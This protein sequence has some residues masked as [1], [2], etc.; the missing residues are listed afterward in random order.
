MLMSVA[1]RFSCHRVGRCLLGILVV[2]LLAP[3]PVPGASADD[4]LV[5]AE[6]AL[7]GI[8]K[9]LDS[10]KG[11]SDQ[12]LTAL[13]EEIASIRD[14]AFACI[15]EAEEGIDKLDSELLILR[16]QQIVAHLATEDRAGSGA[17]AV[18]AR[19]AVF[20]HIAEQIQVLPHG[21]FITA[22][23][24]VDAQIRVRIAVDN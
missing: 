16:P 5:Q 23:R 21:S 12:Q 9:R 2:L 13:E 22:N 20:E 7:D 8:E 24:R 11:L 17:G 18:G 6:S 15:Q 1:A 10:P 4:P 19:F 14:G 3:L